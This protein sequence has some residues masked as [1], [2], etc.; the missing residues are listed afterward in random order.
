MKNHLILFL[1]FP[2]LAVGQVKSEALFE[3]YEVYD[4]ITSV[5]IT[6]Q[7]FTLVDSFIANLA[8][9]DKS[10]A[11]VKELLPKMNSMKVLVYEGKD[12]PTFFYTDI[13]Q[14]LQ[15]NY[16]ILMN[17]KSSNPNFL[18][19]GTDEIIHEIVLLADNMY[20]FLEGNFTKD[21]VNTIVEKFN[22]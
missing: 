19:D 1:W 9:E 13:K 14:S 17:G 3:K 21:E 11:P 5:L 8:R 12:F 4:N 7:M 22:K 6:K 16:T 10:L 20:V 15:K 18:I 2:I